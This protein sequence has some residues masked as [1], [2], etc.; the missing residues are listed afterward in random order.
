MNGLNISLS[1]WIIADGNY[2]HFHRGQTAEFALTFHQKFIEPTQT[3]KRA[4]AL[5]K[6]CLYKATAEV[7]F[8]S[9]SV[10][11]LDF[12]PQ[13]YS[14]SPISPDFRSGDF[15]EVEFL[16]GIDPFYYFS[17]HHKLPAMLPLIYTWQVD[18][19]IARSAPL[20]KKSD[21]TGNSWFAPDEANY[22]YR[23]VERTEDRYKDEQDFLLNRNKK[24][25]EYILNCTRLDIEPAFQ[26][27][28]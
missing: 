13:A 7:V 6:D 25:L 14:A 3:K 4:L 24:S 8:D 15:I 11:V 18:K 28:K 1:P 17:F 16:L 5:V 27:S 19:I 12:G 26:R 2:D 9:P 10:Y 23:E 20:L 22:S 21:A